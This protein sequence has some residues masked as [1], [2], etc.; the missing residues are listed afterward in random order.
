MN[1]YLEFKMPNF[2]VANLRNSWLFRAI[3]AS[4]LNI[5]NL[6]LFRPDLIRG[7]LV[8]QDEKSM[9]SQGQEL[10]ILEY[11]EM[12]CRYNDVY[13]HPSNKLNEIIKDG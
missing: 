3:C 7:S 9:F 4:N 1:E 10:A 6:N 8:L 13:L 5:L 2:F 12:Q 11:V